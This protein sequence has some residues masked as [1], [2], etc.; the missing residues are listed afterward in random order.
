MQ[1]PKVLIFDLETSE[2]NAN[3]GHIMCAVAKW[4][5]E[6]WHYEWR[7]DD[8]P[9]YGTTPRSWYY[10]RDIAVELRDLC[11]EA[12]VVVAYYGAYG[13]FDVPFLNTRLLSHQE[14]PCRQLSVVDP[15]TIAKGKLKL[16][17]NNMD[18]VGALLGCEHQKY[19]LPWA[20]W[21]HAKYGDRE[22]M[23]RILEYCVNDVYTLEDIYKTLLPL[24]PTH[25]RAYELPWSGQS[26]PCRV[27]GGPTYSKGW[28]YNSKTRVHDIACKNKQGTCG[29]RGYGR[30]ERLT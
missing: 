22:G 18:S 24:A 1:N 6:D 19:H 21:H 25:P 8:D 29:W 28:K 4:L 26:E 5:N 15:Y 11:E 12:N 17:R 3:R 2:L 30:T 16:A 9:D 23:D 20:D 10:D 13:K 14:R 7:I 27:C